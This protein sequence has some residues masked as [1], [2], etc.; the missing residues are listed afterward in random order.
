MFTNLIEMKVP[1]KMPAI[2]HATKKAGFNMP[3]EPKTGS[4]LATLAASKPAGNLLELGTGTGLATSWLLYGMDQQA[5]LMSVDNDAAVQT[6]ARE[7]LASD[8]RVT[9]ITSPGETFLREAKHDQYDLIF[10][11][12]WPGKYW[13]LDLALAALKPGGLYIIDDM[14]PQ[15]S[16]PEGHAPKVDELRLILAQHPQLIT[17]EM[18]WASGLII[19]V[20]LNGEKNE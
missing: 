2:S 9:F 5:H 10:A 8:P 4:L 18:D 1:E 15:S 16:W 19:C 3:S 13:D 20:K 12:A 11:D 7:Q 17:T 14:L 6:I